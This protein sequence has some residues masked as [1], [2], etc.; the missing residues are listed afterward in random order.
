M[1]I[2]LLTRQLSDP[3]CNRTVHADT[4]S[5]SDAPRRKSLELPRR[6]FKRGP[7]L[8]SLH[9][10]QLFE[11]AAIHDPACIFTLQPS[12]DSI[13]PSRYDIEPAHP[14]LP[15]PSCPPSLCAASPNANSFPTTKK[16]N[17]Q[18][19]RSKVKRPIHCRLRSRSTWS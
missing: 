11:Q 10:D 7:P 3:T 17:N 15:L 2:P 13:P 1:S 5:I 16:L 4:S 12:L 9:L 6:E 14:Q 8:E 18:K 19:R